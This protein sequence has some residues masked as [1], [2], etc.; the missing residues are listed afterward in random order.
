M[1]V[2]T[3]KMNWALAPILVAT[4]LTACGGGGGGGGGVGV[5][6]GCGDG[7]SGGGHGGLR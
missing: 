3:L 7:G 1:K 6:G 2:K 5:G 4:L